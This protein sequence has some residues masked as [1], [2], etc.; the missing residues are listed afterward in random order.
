M[1]SAT[2]YKNIAGGAESGWDF[3]SRWLQDGENLYSIDT[4]NVTPICLNSIMLRFELNMR[5]LNEKLDR[6]TEASTFETAAKTRYATM[7]STMWDDKNMN[8]N[9]LYEDKHTTPTPSVSAAN[10][11]PLW[12]WAQR[13]DATL[14][15][16]NNSTMIQVVQSL[17]DSGLI[18]A[19]GVR[20]TNQA[21]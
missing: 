21:T 16:I 15:G 5:Y 8:W 18:G 14:L 10:Y 17:S 20:A 2:T 11:M 19:A 3:T 7:T 9:D 1:D 6:T 12:A 4:T 13:D